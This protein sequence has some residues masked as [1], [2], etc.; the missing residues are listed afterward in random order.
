MQEHIVRGRHTQNCRAFA[1]F[2]AA[3]EE[4]RDDGDCRQSDAKQQHGKARF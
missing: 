3:H 4:E 1:I 2:R